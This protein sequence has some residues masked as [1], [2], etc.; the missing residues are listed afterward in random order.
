MSQAKSPYNI[1]NCIM[2]AIVVLA[3]G[4]FCI[5]TD[6]YAPSFPDMVQYFG[7]SESRIQDIITWNFI[8]LF[9]STLFYGPMSD[10][11]GRK[12]LLCS[13]LLIFSLS[14]VACTFATSVEQLIFFRFLQGLG[15]G[16][17]TG[18]GPAMVFDV[19]PSKESAKLIT[20]LNSFVT[21]MIALAPLVGSWV[22]LAFG[23]RMNFIIVAVISVLTFVTAIFLLQETLPQSKRSTFDLK[24]MLKDYGGLL[25]HFNF[26]GHTIIWTSIFGMLIL[27]TA[28]QSLIF[29]EY[30][31]VDPKVFGY[32]QAAVMATFF[33]GS[34]IA[35][36]I[37]EWFG[38]QTAKRI[39]N[40][41]FV[42]GTLS[43]ALVAQASPPSPLFLTLSMCLASSGV[44]IS[45][46]IHYVDSIADTDGKGAATALGQA[47]RLIVSAIMVAIGTLTFNGSMQPIVMIGLGTVALMLFLLLGL[48]KPQISPVQDPS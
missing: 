46:T 34:L 29:I 32:Y 3:Y 19:F 37:I 48:R 7:T 13:G 23:W 16:A 14:S 9:L 8:G 17:I 43:L 40:T 42:L 15:C 25:I 4:A 18:I 21:G 1:Q 47:M 30:L 38:M 12:P 10:A 5:E 2:L 20:I 31:H 35:N 36:R 39:G 6:I 11:Y 22:N 41:A 27:F 44:A 24:G 26:M 28:N 33:A 45:G